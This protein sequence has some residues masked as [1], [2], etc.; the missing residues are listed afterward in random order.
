MI[1]FVILHYLV[2]DITKQCVDGLLKL[3]SGEQIQIAVV[4]NASPNGS[5]PRL[6]AY[7]RDQANVHVLLNKEND[8]F[9]R[10]N[11]VGYDY[12][13]Q[14][15]APDFMVVMNNDV[16]I[17]QEDFLE[18]IRNN[19]EKTNFAVLG[20]DIYCPYSKTHQNPSRM[21]P[22]TLEQVRNLVTDLEHRKA[23]YGRWYLKNRVKQLLHPA[24]PSNSHQQ[25]LDWTQPLENPVLHGACYI[26]SK[27]YMQQRPYC[28]YP[29]TFLYCEEEILHLECTAANL[30]TCYD[31]SL[32]VHHLED[33]ST[34]AVQ[35]GAFQ[36]AKRK[37][38]L[39]LTSARLLLKLYEQGGNPNAKQPADQGPA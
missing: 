31:P 21:T 37:N 17:Y 5:G 1:G 4:D 19:Y 22:L 39:V 13:L 10:G 38:D 32:Q 8:G 11:N 14:Q 7:Y 30:K 26:F 16:M 34:N 12:L 23:H 9:A 25:G 28:F 27:A 24:K 15:Y 33:M 6:E 35:K 2:E 3:F 36:K 29:E 18:K 20:P